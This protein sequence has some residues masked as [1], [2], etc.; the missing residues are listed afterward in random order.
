MR[1]RTRLALWYGGTA[2]VLVMLSCAYGYAV[3]SRTHYDELDRSLEA[4]GEHVADELATTPSRSEQLAVVGRAGYMGGRLSLL[5]RG[6]HAASGMPAQ[7]QSA[8]PY[9]IVPALLGGSG[10]SSAAL[11]MRV[12][13]GGGRWRTWER[14]ITG[15]DVRLRAEMPLSA[16][17]VSVAAFR[18][19]MVAMALAGAMAAFA[20]GSLVARRAT[21]PLAAVTRAAATIARTRTFSQRVSARA[22][23]DEL[24]DLTDTLNRMLASLET[25]HASL[26]RFTA[27]ASHELRAPLTVVQGNLDVA[28]REE[29]GAEERA[30]ALTDAF[31]AAQRM[32]KLVSDL[33]V[34]A[35]A[36]A[37][38]TLRQVP[39]DLAEL[40]LE[41][42]G[43]T[44]SLLSRHDFSVRELEEARVVGDAEYLRRLLV[45]LLDNAVKYT[46][47]GGAISLRLHREAG[48]A[49]M[50]V[51]DEGCGIDPVHLP[52]VFDRFYRGDEG[53]L[54]ERGGTGLGLAIAAWIVEA[55]G[56][57]IALD[58]RPGDGTVASV[59]LPL[60][61]TGRERQ[62]IG[63]STSAAGVPVG[64][65]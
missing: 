43:E 37:G 45:I 9:G 3:H 53:R 22:R 6:G 41:V 58:T 29:L 16:L 40:V 56:G 12:D 18:Q 32:G 10:A 25:A 47:E 34:L 1:L 44:G 65:A 7:S 21:E 4:L 63:S 38:I 19:R 49:V 5:P 26:Q 31:Q 33:L 17:D 20:I 27:D 13:A 24:K 35:R 11:G 30:A 64:A 61:G 46:D 60:V 57:D 8:R 14:D 23:D 59:R 2:G 62:A 51:R 48:M 39:L 36:D 15:Q 42:L 54:S 55:H 52:R 50:T 28:Q